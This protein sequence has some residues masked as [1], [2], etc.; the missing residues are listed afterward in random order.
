VD[1]D[2]EE[3]VERARAA[4]ASHFHDAAREAAAPGAPGGAAR[5]AASE[6][7]NR[8]FA[9]I[10]ARMQDGEGILPSGLVHPDV[11]AAISAS[12]GKGRQLDGGLAGTLE[13]A[14]GGSLEGVRV[15]TDNH[16]AALARAVSARAFAVGT[17]IYFGAGEYR[18]GSREGDQLI[19]HEAAHVVQQRGA[20][21]D[22]PLTVSQ[23]GDEMEREAEA[24]AH[25]VTG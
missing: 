6:V 2:F 18:P 25:D 19:A 7:G 12:R 20:P 10:V 14:F 3:D 1:A 9:Q 13:D 11:E 23:P 5:R 17:D 21:M 4:P 16:A 15:H 24:L 22:G 8:G